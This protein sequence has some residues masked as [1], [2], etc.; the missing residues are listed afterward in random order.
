M[1]SP[2]SRG[3][4]WTDAP[5]RDDA[6][7]HLRHGGG[8]G[9]SSRLACGRRRCASTAA[10]GRAEPRRA[11]DPDAGGPPDAHPG[12]RRLDEQR[13]ALVAAGAP[14]DAFASARLTSFDA[15]ALSGVYAWSS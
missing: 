11:G 4:C 7:R 6:A 8:G 15:P 13:I 14:I 1:A 5:E 12:Q 3:R 2:T 9:K 10:T